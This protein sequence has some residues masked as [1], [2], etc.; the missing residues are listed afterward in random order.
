MQ[1]YM[2]PIIRGFNPDPSICRVGNEYFLVTSSFE[3]FPGVPIYKSTNLVNWSRIGHCL[4]RKSQLS[5]ENCKASEGIYAPTIRYHNGKFYMVTTNVSDKGNLIVSTEDIYGEWSE[6]VRIDQCGIDPSLLFVDDK[7]YFVSNADEHGN[8]GI[9][10]CEINPDTGEK[11]SRSCLISKGCGGKYPEAPHV[12]KRNGFYYL[13]LAEGGTEYG[14]MVT[15][16]RSEN[17]YGPYEP[18][19]HNPILSHRAL[20]NMDISCV[21]HADLTEDQCGNWWMDGCSGNKSN[22]L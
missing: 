8:S 22:F 5:L 20:E 11:F 12:Y 7:V 3:F 4:T 6:P 15:I 18:C 19:P 14:H 21:G 9:Y 2:N 16:Q 1:T 10:M 17:P 13:M